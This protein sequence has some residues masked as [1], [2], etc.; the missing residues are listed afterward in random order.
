M[1]EELNLKWYSDPGHGWL[2]VPVELLRDLDILKDISAHSYLDA[3]RETAYLEEDQD[4]WLF[5][6]A[7]E[8]AGR[9]TREE[10]RTLPE[11]VEPKNDSFVRSMQSIAVIQ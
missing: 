1:N 2:A 7:M 9:M 11:E 10:I 5:T 4:A 6:T 8:K 3:G